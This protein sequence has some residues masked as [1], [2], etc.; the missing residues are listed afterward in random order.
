MS[1]SAP[2]FRTFPLVFSGEVNR[3]ETRVMRLSRVHD[4]S[5]SR[6]DTVP[7]C[8]GQTDGSTIARTALCIASY[9]DALN[10]TSRN[11]NKMRLASNA[12]QKGTMP[13]PVQ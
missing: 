8:D 4:R 11:E 12:L 10:E 5:L 1:H 2:S 7:A 3:E 9:A 13:N 6:F